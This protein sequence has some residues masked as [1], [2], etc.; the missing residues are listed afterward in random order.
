[1]FK[2]LSFLFLSLVS[3]GQ[4]TTLPPASG[5]G[6]G[7]VSSVSAGATGALICSPTTGVIVCDVDP[8]YVPNK[9][10][11]NTWTGA[12]DFSGAT[13]TIPQ[14]MGTSFPATCTKGERYW[15][16]TL[17]VEVTCVATNVWS[18]T[19]GMPGK[20]SRIYD[21]LCGSNNY[22]DNAILGE[23]WFST[24]PN[25]DL[26]SS[27]SDANHVCTFNMYQTG[28][29]GVSGMALRYNSTNNASTFGT[30][31]GLN[32]TVGEFHFV[33]Q[34]NDITQVIYRVGLAS[35]LEQPLPTN[36][37]YAQY[38]SNTGCT[39][40]GTD[41]GWV[42]TTRASSVSS[43]ASGPA[44]TAG[45]WIHLRIRSVTAGTW[46]FSVS[47]NG[48]AFSTE[49]SLSTNVP[50]ANLA[51]VFLVSSCEAVYKYLTADMYAGFVATQ[52]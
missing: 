41:T 7:A 29:N 33:F 5:S 11:S 40:T 43:T 10:G 22:P 12:N 19:G 52:R 6:G 28:A 38:A 36:G 45:T 17:D 27:L 21:E 14:K 42:Y 16:N 20:F 30:V 46:L 35:G 9:T 15:H 37:I 1:M 48:G 49:Q 51:P 4:I 39:L 47:V 25:A 26:G 31:G 44:L 24:G 50:S 2:Y 8:L 32:T 13:S 23:R 18:Y 3:Y 34:P